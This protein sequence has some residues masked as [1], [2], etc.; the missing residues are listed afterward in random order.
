VWTVGLFLNKLRAYLRKVRAK[1]VRANLRH[2]IKSGRSR[3]NPHISESILATGRQI[4]IR[5]SRVVHV[6]MQPGPLDTHLTITILY[7]KTL[8]AL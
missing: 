7:N 3:L 5:R 6:L 8:G 2:P 4:E 1:G